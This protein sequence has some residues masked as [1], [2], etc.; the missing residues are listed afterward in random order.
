MERPRETSTTG[1]RSGPLEKDTLLFSW[2]AAE[3]Q[4]RRCGMPIDGNLYLHHSGTIIHMPR[5]SQLGDKI[6]IY[7]HSGRLS[8]PD[9]P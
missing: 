3:E 4:R 1:L 5:N 2:E 7:R 9:T 8:L 6:V